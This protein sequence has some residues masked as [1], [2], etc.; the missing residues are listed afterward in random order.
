MAANR[1]RFWTGITLAVAVAGM[2]ALPRALLVADDN[3]KRQEG[4]GKYA[5]L[6]AIWW[7]WVYAQPAIDVGATNTNPLLDS[8]GAYA[9]AGQQGGIGPAN[10][11]FFL[12]G[13]LGGE[14]TR[15]G[16]RA[17]GQNPLLPC[18]ELRAGQLAPDQPRSQP[19]PGYG[20]YG[21]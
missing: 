9:S 3:G 18:G 21:A 1:N 15:H 5:E 7:Q 12:A 13:G 10:K 4:Q 2:I 6:T 20:L 17:R 8:T 14:I 11:Y 19:A 16:D